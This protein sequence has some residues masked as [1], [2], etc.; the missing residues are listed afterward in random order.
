MT[1][2]KYWLGTLSRYEFF[3]DGSVPVIT[4]VKFI[5]YLKEVVYSLIYVHKY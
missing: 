1:E 4:E 3:V 2:P 5:R